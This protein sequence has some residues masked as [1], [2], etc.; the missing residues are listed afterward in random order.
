MLTIERREQVEQ[1]KFAKRALF[2]PKA[3]F[4]PPIACKPSDIRALPETP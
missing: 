3:P 4:D 1:K 2:L